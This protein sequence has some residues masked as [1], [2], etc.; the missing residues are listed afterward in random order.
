[1]AVQFHNRYVLGEFELEPEKYLLKHHNQNVHLAELPF[2]V[3]IYLIEN[4]ERYVSRQELLERFWQG[5]D[6]YEETLTKCISTIRTQ[7][8]D[9]PSEPRFIKT[10]KKVGYR[11]VGPL[12]Q[13]PVNVQPPQ[14]LTFEQSQALSILIEEHDDGTP[15]R[16]RQWLKTEEDRPDSIQSTASVT[17]HVAGFRSALGKGLILPGAVIATLLVILSPL[18]RISD[19]SLS[20][21]PTINSLAVLPL[22]NLS[23]DPSQ[24]YFADGMT[25]EVITELAKVAQ[26]RVISRSS[27]IQY[28]PT[29]KTTAEIAEE[30]KVDALVKGSVVRSGDRIRIRVQ[31]I[32]AAT[33]KHLWAHSYERD[34]RD[35]LSLQ[36]DVGRAIA[37]E[38]TNRLTPS[39][40]SVVARTVKPESVDAYLR[41]RDYLNKARN[42]N[43]GPS[44]DD[45]LN[46]SIS[47]FQ[48]AIEIQ[49]DYAMAYSGLARAYLWSAKI[50]PGVSPSAVFPK[51]REAATK[52]LE[53]DPTS[54]E[55]HAALAFVLQI[56]DR[57]EHNAGHEFK[58]AIELNPSYADARHGYALYLTTFGRHDEAIQ[59]ITLAEQLDPL[60]M[61]IK[62]ELA[63]IYLLARQY[64]KAIEAGKKALEADPSYNALHAIVGRGY[65]HKGMY[66][67]GIAELHKGVGAGRR[68]NLAVLAWAYAE[69]GN[70]SAAVKSLN[71]A[72]G[73]QSQGEPISA[74]NIAAVYSALG[75]KD[76]AFAWLDRAERNFYGQVLQINVDPA[77]ESL[78]SDQRFGD[79]V[80]RLKLTP[81]P[82]I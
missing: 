70:N 68:P 3:L 82:P 29:S 12:D 50:T 80:R 81:A 73:R 48:D 56:Y 5:S 13:V 6:S 43:V 26:Q 57:D 41:A 22:E 67:L 24:D 46:T 2:Q 9:S 7:L 59:E 10:R 74:V 47:C 28:K 31:L 63:R 36:R 72:I 30:L 61:P 78:R 65:I 38:I 23:G 11:Y 77:F 18:W 42:T 64:D 76:R 52:A 49:P 17:K 66:R 15:V 14:T 19:S 69:S 27:I 37:A 62:F 4:R 34:I 35:I 75:D 54:G 33:E 20:I 44:A 16:E 40:L 39:P 25:E 60:L 45:F 32:H 1:M 53:L 8:D 51:A 58:R 79:L 71:E 55:A 21:P